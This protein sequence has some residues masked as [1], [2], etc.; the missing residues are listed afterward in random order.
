LEEEA[1]KK[2]NALLTFCNQVNPPVATIVKLNV[3]GHLFETTLDTLC[4]YPDSILGFLF[5]GKHE[6]QRDANGYYFL[7]RDGKAFH[8]LLTWLQNYKLSELS[9]ERQSLLE[10]EIQF[11]KLP[12]KE[13]SDDKGNYGNES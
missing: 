4:K 1:K 13:D 5:S 7:H 12:W 3:G 2:R 11:W 8:L 10:Q 9:P 6:L